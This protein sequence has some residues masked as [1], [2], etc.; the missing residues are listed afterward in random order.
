MFQASAVRC[1]L[2][3]LFLAACLVGARPAEAGAWQPIGPEGGQV[4]T[5]EVDAGAPGT[6]Y[7]GTNAGVF[8]SSDGAGSWALTRAGLPMG[9]VTIVKVDP[10]DSTVVFAAV[11]NHGLWKSTDG[12]ASWTSASTG[13]PD[14]G[15]FQVLALAIDPQSPATLYAAVQSFIWKSIDGGGSWTRQSPLRQP[16]VARSL[17]IAPGPPHPI[18]AGTPQGVLRSSDGG[19]TWQA[20]SSQPRPQNVVALAFPPGAADTLFVASQDSGIWR[21]DDGGETWKAGGLT[22]P[23]NLLTTAVVADPSSPGVLYAAAANPEDLSTPPNGA[24]FRSLDDSVTW[25]QVQV[26]R[27]AERVLALDLDPA[28][29]S[30][31]FAATDNGV[32]RSVNRFRRWSP[33]NQGL[34]AQQVV[35][36]AVDGSRG[37]TLYAVADLGVY[38]TADGGRSWTL[39]HPSRFKPGIAL[40]PQGTLYLSTGESLLASGDGGRSFRTLLR[41][42][43]GPVAVDPRHPRTLYTFSGAV[44]GY[45]VKSTNGG[46]TWRGSVTGVGCLYPY[47]LFV[48]PGR[49]TTLFTAGGFFDLGCQFEGVPGAGLWKSFDAGIHWS[50]DQQLN[51]VSDLD[52]DPFSAATIYAA[53]GSTLWKSRDGGN[54]WSPRAT[55]PDLYALAVDPTTPGVLFAGRFVSRDGGAHFALVEGDAGALDPG[56]VVNRLVFDPAAPRT[57]YAAT[58]SGLFRL[59]HPPG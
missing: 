3:F 25:Q 57:L 19:A 12:G 34:R 22:L 35:Q 47:I 46:R 36:V 1:S 49:T 4:L 58:S 5:L 37:G 10:R 21:S 29:P 40:D 44:Q 9:R 33:A 8:K 48:D 26:G 23:A 17:A 39:I 51:V 2:L 43:F 24:V 28:A 16:F 32:F 55:L 56:I 41:P 30:H 27:P 54:T 38:R 59:V 42:S 14:A 11:E 52:A 6:V 13:L 20:S 15:S 7:A 18:F 53:D 45:S 50:Q 31:L